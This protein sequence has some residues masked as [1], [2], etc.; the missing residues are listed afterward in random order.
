MS[1]DSILPV[2]RLHPNRTA[3]NELD[4]NSQKRIVHVRCT[5]YRLLS[6]HKGQA[7]VLTD[8]RVHHLGSTPVKCAH[9]G[10]LCRYGEARQ[11]PLRVYVLP[12]HRAHLPHTSKPVWRWTTPE[13]AVTP[14]KHL[15]HCNRHTS[16][17][18]M[19]LER[20]SVE[21]TSPSG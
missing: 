15:E 1:L 6:D 13:L 3:H 20:H 17:H 4:V 5:H 8:N 14:A 19:K 16:C 21:R 7:T 11:T 12:N 18:N 9:A 10:A 2:H